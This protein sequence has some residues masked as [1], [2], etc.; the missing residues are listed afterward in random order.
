MKDGMSYENKSRRTYNRLK[1]AG[2]PVRL[3]ALA[4][5]TLPSCAAQQTGDAAEWLK[6]IGMELRQLRVELL[7][8]RMAEEGER[9]LQ[10]QRDLA[11]L[12]L[13]Q[14]K[15]QS[16]EQSLKQQLSELDKNASDPNADSQARAQIQTIKGE[17][18]ATAELTR[19]AY[20]TLSAREA[21]L[22][23]RLQAARARLQSITS[24]LRLLNAHSDK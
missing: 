9:I 16:E 11:A 4:V 13:E 23:E 15:H 5:A 21:D 7:E 2:L 1:G 3:L 10:M 17:L 24:R 12:R 20:S 14:N 19:V 18:A 22:N 6:F 8:N